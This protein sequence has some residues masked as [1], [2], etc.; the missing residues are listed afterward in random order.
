MAKIEVTVQIIQDA[1]AGFLKNKVGATKVYNN[2]N[3]QGTEFPAWFIHLIPLT[4]ISYP[5]VGGRLLRNFQIDLV[6]TEQYNLVD[7][8]DIYLQKAEEMDYL[9]EY[10]EYPYKV[11]NED[12]TVEIEIALIRPMNKEWSIDLQSL[13]YKFQLN[14]HVRRYEGDNPKMMV[15]E[16]L[17]EYV[18]E[19]RE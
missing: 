14:L 15:I 6:Y 5:A 2:P 7:L 12:G 19:Y 9:L 13:H 4:G 8:Y 3:Q 10:I 18:T 1:I 11:L 17:H 16:E